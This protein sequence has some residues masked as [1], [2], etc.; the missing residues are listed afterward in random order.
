MI[1]KRKWL[2]KLITIILILIAI[3]YCLYSNRNKSTVQTKI[4]DQRSKITSTI[5]IGKNENYYS[6]LD[7]LPDEITA[8]SFILKDND[9]YYL[10]FTSP[11]DGIWMM[12]SENLSS[13][14]EKIKIFDNPD[15]KLFNEFYAPEVYKINGTYYMV[16]SGVWWNFEENIEER[17]D[18]Y[19][20]TTQSLS[21]NGSELNNKFTNYKKIDLGMG[22]GSRNIDGNLLIDENENRYLYFKSEID[23]KIYVIKIDDNFNR[24]SEPKVILELNK[25]SPW[26]KYQLEGTYCFKN[27]GTYYLLYTSGAY[28]NNTYMVGYATS[29]VPDNNFVKKTVSGPLIQGDNTVN[30]IYNSRGIYGTGH[31]MIFKDEMNKM[32]CVYHRAT[33]NTNNSFRYR[34]VTMDRINIID[35]EL[36][37][38][39]P[40]KEN[41]PL[42]SGTVINGKK[43][44]TLDK[45]YQGRVKVDNRETSRL[46]DGMTFNSK[47]NNTSETGKKFEIELKNRREI[48][49]LWLYSDNENSM[50]GKSVTITLNDRYQYSLN[51]DKENTMQIVLPIIEEGIYKIKIE[52]E[53]N[54]T[55]S[56]MKITTN[57][58]ENYDE[59]AINKIIDENQQ[60]REKYSKAYDNNDVTAIYNKLINEIKL[61]GSYENDEEKVKKINNV[62]AQ[63]FDLIKKIMELNHDKKIVLS[64]ED[65]KEYINLIRKITESYKDIYSYYIENDNIENAKAI[66]NS[67]IEKYNQNTDLNIQYIGELIENAVKVYNEKISD[68]NITYR[69]LARMEI[70]NTCNIADNFLKVET[71]KAADEDAKKVKFTMDKTEI[72][73]SNV[74][75]SV[76]LPCKN[77]F[78]KDNDGNNI[79]FYENDVRNI[80]IDIRGYEYTYTIKVNNI[81]KTVP[82]ITAQNGQSLKINATDDNLKEIKIEKDGKEIAVNNGQTITTPGIYKITATDKAGNSTNKTAIVYGTYINEQNSE[83]NYVTIKSK[84]KVSDVKQDGDYTVKDNNSIIAGVKRAPSLVNTNTEKDSNSYIATGDILQDNNN[85]YIVITLGDLSSNG[86]VGAA[87]LIK[88]RKSLVGLTKLTKLQELAADTNQNGSVNVSDL[89]KERK[90]MVGAE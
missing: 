45:E 77:S 66:L 29:S 19:V 86:D 43:I 11:G 47:K 60:I 90:I 22:A 63:Q 31:P 2:K 16:F 46:N 84:T 18:L 57:N 42:P 48:T 61:A 67:V 41:Q 12:Q 13:W 78:I 10:F 40:T 25:N 79:V 9:Y 75:V 6:N 4:L 69:Y 35:N 7:T 73:N 28:A 81:D 70:I 24:I 64:S 52:F 71:Q 65:E 76:N 55:L 49:D 44:Y 83:V 39:G 37:L 26:E 14:S 54:Q 27:N 5:K 50:K 88:L 34:R 53:T 17:A 33:F 80:K 23:R 56:E 87:D 1:R 59:K 21:N 74:I 30:G 15:K 89:L 51:I 62:Y 82:K 72:T 58:L 36:I 20:A 68:E 85:T 8:D 38:D 32:Y 3:Y